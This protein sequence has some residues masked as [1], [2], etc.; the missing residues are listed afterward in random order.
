MAGVET[1]VSLRGV[2]AKM[3]ERG[4][5]DKRNHGSDSFAEQVNVQW[6]LTGRTRG[7]QGHG[8][9]GLGLL[10]RHIYIVLAQSVAIA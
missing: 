7:M 1:L 9:H 10:G 8:R 5:R 3:S 2:G 4:L 6:A